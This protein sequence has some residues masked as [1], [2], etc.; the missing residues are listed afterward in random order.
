MSTG[1]VVLLKLVRWSG[2][3]LIP[4]VA[5]FLVTGYIMSGQFG[6]DRFLDEKRALAL[7]RLLHGPLL[8]LLL[9]HTV[10]A[11]YL[12]LQRWGWIRPRVKP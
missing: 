4:V 6:F 1:N 3:P 11:V 12:A 9:A 2:W 10:P 5:A 7:H 8:V